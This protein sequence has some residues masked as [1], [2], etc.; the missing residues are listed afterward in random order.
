[1]IQHVQIIQVYVF[2]S[3]I[4]LLLQYLDILEFGCR[5]YGGTLKKAEHNLID[6]QR[7]DLHLTG[8]LGV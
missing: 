3:I 1:M 5:E 4:I 8:H 6:N 2:S 7:R